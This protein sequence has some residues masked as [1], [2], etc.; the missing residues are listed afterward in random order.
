[1]KYRNNKEADQHNNERE[2]NENEN[3]LYLPALLRTI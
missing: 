2:Y 1:M 3:Y